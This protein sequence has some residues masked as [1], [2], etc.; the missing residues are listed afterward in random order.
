M[1]KYQELLGRDSGAEASMLHPASEEET[2]P[3]TQATNFTGTSMD[4]QYSSPTSAMN[5]LTSGV[6]F[7]PDED[8]LGVH[9]DPY[10]LFDTPL[11]R[12]TAFELFSE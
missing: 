9:H 4:S 12:G 6:C 5:V 2:N 11:D 3:L 10:M 1:S 8:D 7:R